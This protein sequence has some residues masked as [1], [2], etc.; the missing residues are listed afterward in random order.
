M[1]KKLDIGTSEIEQVEAFNA[2]VDAVNELQ[3]TLDNY[4]KRFR[5]LDDENMKKLHKGLR[6]CKTHTQNN[7]SGLERCVNFG[8]MTIHNYGMEF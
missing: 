1:L 8:T 2:L 5:E 3:T 7:A 4:T 6:T